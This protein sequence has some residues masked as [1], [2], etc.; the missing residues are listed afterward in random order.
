[1]HHHGDGCPLGGGDDR[2][3]DE[4]QFTVGQKHLGGADDDGG[5]ALLGGG[6]DR[7]QHIGVGGIEEA[8]GVV[9]LLRVGK[10][11]VEV[12]EHGGTPLLLWV[13]NLGLSLCAKPNNEE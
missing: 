9:I 8:D 12:D 13:I 3:G 10:D 6:N 7:L 4:L 5:A 2:G 11:G 1:M